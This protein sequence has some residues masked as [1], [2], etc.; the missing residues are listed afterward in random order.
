MIR[1]LLSD[2]SFEDSLKKHLSAVARP[3]DPDENFSTLC[4]IERYIESELL[5]YGYQVKRDPIPY[6]GQRFNNLIAQ[7]KFLDSRQPRFVVAAHFDAVTGTEGADD[8]A[9][10]VACLLEA[11]RTLADSPAASIVDWIAFNLEEEGMVGSSHYV[12]RLK[13]TETKLLGMI[14]LEMVGFTSEEPGSQRL[15]IFLKPFYPDKGNFL[16]LVGNPASQK[17]LRQAHRAFA[18]ADGLPVECLTLP[19]NGRLLPETRL[20]DHSPF[21]DAGY[22]ALLVTDTSF[23][24]NPYYHTSGDRI[25]TLDLNFLKRVCEGTIRLVEDIGK[26]RGD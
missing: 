4:E 26:N 15:P 8:N 22:P 7:K 10:G 24:R 14:S 12:R 3:R 13:Q 19:F 11:A 16:A 20:S 25:E 1:R 2:P 18:A 23:F 5:S 6:R 17:L 21:W 9:S